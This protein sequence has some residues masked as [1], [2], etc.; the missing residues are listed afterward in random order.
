MKP[1]AIFVSFLTLFSSVMAVDILKSVLI[2]YPPETPDSVVNKAKAAVVEAGGVI[3]HEYT[4][5]K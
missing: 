4:L 5:I 1:F 2:T 3:T